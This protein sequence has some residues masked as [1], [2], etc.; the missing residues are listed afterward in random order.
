MIREPMERIE[1]SRRGI[2]NSLRPWVWAIP[3]LLSIQLLWAAQLKEETV[4]AW[5]QYLQW[6]N[7][8]VKKELADPH[9]FLI[10]NTLPS[11][12]KAS[13][14]KEIRDEKIFVERM[15]SI[16][17][18]GMD[19]EV[20]DGAIHHYWGTILLK[21][22]KLPQLMKFL[23]DYNHHAG[24]FADVERSGKLEEK[25]NYYKVYFRLK[26]SKSFVTAVYNTEQECRYT[27]HGSNRISSQSVATK[28]A[29][30]D[31]PGKAS[32]RE[33]TPGDDRGFLWRLVSW[34]RFEQAGNDVIVE[35]ESASLSR[36]IPTLVKLIPGV[37]GYIQ[38]TPKETLESV[39]VS[40]R[41]NMGQ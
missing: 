5:D 24:K 33:K 1:G 15:P 41:K 7:A 39:L 14:Q 28:I 29:E 35:L 3:V 37:I 36:D 31:N 11:K 6:A 34:W 25:E 26:R 30:L 17:P 21:N 20:P 27:Y 2:A 4:R 9:I 16:V 18:P 12:K 10:Q 40:I 8:K 32:E 38:S 23:Q 22:V 13:I 19:F